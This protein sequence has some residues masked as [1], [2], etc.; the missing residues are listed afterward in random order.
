MLGGKCSSVL[1]DVHGTPYFE[2]LGSV[3]GKGAAGLARDALDAVQ[4]RARRFQVEPE[5]L[6]DVLPGIVGQHL[7]GN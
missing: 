5:Y 6:R 7:I 2:W 4:P 1:N 3:V